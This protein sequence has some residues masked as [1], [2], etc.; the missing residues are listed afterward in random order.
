MRKCVKK[1][2]VSLM[3]LM[4]TAFSVISASA[5]SSCV[6]NG[7]L[8]A[9]VGD[10]VTYNLYIAD[11]P[12]KVEDLQIEITYNGDC[13]EAIDKSVKYPDGGSSVYNT[14]I[15][16][17][18]LFNS[19]NGIE[20]WDFKEKTLLLGV[21]FNVKSGGESDIK[22]YI[23]C[24]D[25]LSNSQ[26]V[27]SY[28]LTTEY[29]VNDKVVE[30]GKPPIVDENGQGGN[31]VNYDNGKGE[32]NG[33][34]NPVGG[35]G[36]YGGQANN[37]N[38]A[39]NGNAGNADNGNDGN[40]NGNNNADNN[41]NNGNNAN[42]NAGNGN[43]VGQEATANAGGETSTTAT[44]VVLTNSSGVAITTPDGKQATWTDSKNMWRNIGIVAGALAVV[45]C[46]VITVII[47]KKKSENSKENNS[48][49]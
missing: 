48:E 27:D 9:K 37:G 42:N 16:G 25:Y 43:V 24:M 35:D 22:Q 31:F 41:V 36:A 18:V 49:R 46:I 10:K 44:T 17:R 13:L 38:D 45:A 7:N 4:I 40:N 29:L 11:V 12:E 23:Q 28:V 5:D 1:I 39:N 14:K 32:K 26:S 3:I 2:T 8:K 15:E 33:G 47:R 20:G 30:E 6:I 19:A 21:S 34:K